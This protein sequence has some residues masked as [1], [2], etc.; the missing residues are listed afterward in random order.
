MSANP[1][2]IAKLQAF[3]ENAGFEKVLEIISN[4]DKLTDAMEESG[5]P[6]DAIELPYWYEELTMEQASEIWEIFVEQAEEHAKEQQKQDLV[7]A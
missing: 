2:D 7:I 1:K 3:I 6:D 5:F 4:N